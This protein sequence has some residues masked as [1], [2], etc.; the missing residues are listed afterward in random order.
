MPFCSRKKRDWEQ[1]NV[2]MSFCPEEKKK[3]QMPHDGI[4]C[5]SSQF[6]DD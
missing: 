4:I 5:S 6:R 3:E 2:F 1:T